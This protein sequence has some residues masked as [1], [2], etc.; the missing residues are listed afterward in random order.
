MPA[1]D[2]MDLMWRYAQ[3]GLVEWRDAPQELRRRAAACLL[4]QI[5][6]NDHQASTTIRT[7][8]TEANANALR[9]IPMPPVGMKGMERCFF[10]PIRERRDD[11]SFAVSFDLFVLVARQN[12]LAFRFEPADPPD[13]PHS[14][15]HVQLCTRLVRKTL[16]LKV[17]PDW[18]P[19]SYPAFPVSASGPVELF[20]AMATSVHGHNRN[21]LARL[22]QD[23]FASVPNDAKHYA[24]DLKSMLRT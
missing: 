18:M 16:I 20:L 9:F 24:A 21:G 10:L 3:R 5:A 19:V 4:N 14:Y 22:L 23:I 13:H 12:C 2:L 8:Y 17:L 15:T 1:P 6:E 7:T 11:G